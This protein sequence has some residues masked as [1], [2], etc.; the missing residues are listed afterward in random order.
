MDCVGLVE[1]ARRSGSTLPAIAGIQTVWS[2]TDTSTGHVNQQAPDVR[3]M[4]A[5]QPPADLIDVV[6][7]SSTE[8]VNCDSSHTLDNALKQ[9]YH[10]GTRR[11][12]GC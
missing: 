8:A 5:L 9:V 6:D 10:R 4:A 3:S 12:N 7:W 1:A 2:Q 11:C